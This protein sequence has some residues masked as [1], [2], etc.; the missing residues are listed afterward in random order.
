MNRHF[1]KALL[2]DDNCPLC[3][4]Y[5]S[6]F[7]KTGMLD[8]DKRISFSQI[9]TADY[10]IDYN[11]ARHEIPLVDFKN[12]E[13]KYG[14]DALAE[15]LNQ[16]FCFVKPILKIGFI[17][18][19]FRK[20]YRV[21]SY[22]RKI[23]VAKPSTPKTCFDCSPDYSVRHRFYLA[24]F[25][26]LSTNFLLANA[27]AESLQKVSAGFKPWWFFCWMLVAI[28]MMIN[29][30]KKQALDIAVH[31]GIIMMVATIIYA[32]LLQFFSIVI[33]ISLNFLFSDFITFFALDDV[34]NKAPHYFSPPTTC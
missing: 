19:F 32:L 3:V 8:A 31:T 34:A 12:G 6:A 10:A 11:K 14:V 4:A 28:S 30:T 15:I 20:L 18:L 33:H 7:V 5:T 23:I 27:V 13:I 26:W 2:Y 9:N 24:L 16:R 1:D 22:N 29:K 25:T 21:I 17:N